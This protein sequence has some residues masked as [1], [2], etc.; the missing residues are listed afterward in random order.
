MTNTPYN[1]LR[2]ILTDSLLNRFVET[3]SPES[4]ENLYDSCGG[5]IDNAYQIGYN[6]GEIDAQNIPILEDILQVLKNKYYEA[7][8]SFV[9]YA[10]VEKIL[11]MYNLTK[12]LAHQS[13]ETLLAIIELL[14]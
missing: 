1:Q 4:S 12:P 8:L 5:N 3:E 14:K 9:N 13:D 11:N 6:E 10:G 7:N 2:Q